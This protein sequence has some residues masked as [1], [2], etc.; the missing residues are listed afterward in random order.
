MKISKKMLSIIMGG[1]LIASCATAELGDKENSSSGRKNASVGKKQSFAC[2]GSTDK[3]DIE[4]LNGGEKIRLTDY[5]GDTH[6]LRLS[7]SASGSY[8]ENERDSFHIKGNEAVFEFDNRTFNCTR[9]Q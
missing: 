9:M 1:V 4:Y 3:V 5:F 6:E 7:K 2:P 8:Y